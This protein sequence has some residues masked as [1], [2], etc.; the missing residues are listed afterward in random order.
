M[1]YLGKKMFYSPQEK[2]HIVLWGDW[3]GGGGLVQAAAT[4]YLGFRGNVLIGFL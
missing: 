2:L 4:S 1:P 3:G